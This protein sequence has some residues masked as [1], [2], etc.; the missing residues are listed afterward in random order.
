MAI[1]KKT[2]KKTTAARKPSG[3]TARPAKGNPA[4]PK[5]G[6][7]KTKAAPKKPAAR[8]TAVQPRFVKTGKGATPLEVGRSLVELVRAGRGSEVEKKWWSP[9][10]VSVE[11]M[12]VSM[13]WAGR[14]AVEDKNQTWE[15]DHIVHS[16]EV[17]GPFVGA[18][19]FAVRFRLD[20]ETK[21]TGQRDKMEEV[22]VYTV[23]DGKI[24]REEF[25]YRAG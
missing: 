19:G 15:A 20:V 14:S 10:V 4:K 8:A 25:M 18:T 12:G 17:E 3:A 1:K 5:S 11:G 2:V 9:A 24:V 16:L 7:K 6:A 21:S 23:Q 13:E 22:G